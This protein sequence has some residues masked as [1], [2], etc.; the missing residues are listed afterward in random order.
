MAKSTLTWLTTILTLLQSSRLLVDADKKP[1]TGLASLRPP[2]L[3]E[4]N[5]AAFVAD[6]TGG[7]SQVEAVVVDDEG[8]T[9]S[10]QVYIPLSESP[11][12]QNNDGPL[13]R[14]ISMLTDILLDVVEEDNPKIRELYDEFL[15]YGKQR[16]VACY[17]RNTRGDME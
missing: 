10:M 6:I 12:V 11:A 2:F 14:D 15:E 1:H 7:A 9:E 5:S 8:A 13:M 17:F 3:K 16:Y 4:S